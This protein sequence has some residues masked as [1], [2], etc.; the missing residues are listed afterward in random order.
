MNISQCVA[1]RLLLYMLTCSTC[2][3]LITPSSHSCTPLSVTIYAP[4]HSLSISETQASEFFPMSF[5]FIY[6]FSV[7]L[8]SSSPFL[9]DSTNI[10]LWG[11]W[12]P[13]IPTLDLHNIATHHRKLFLIK[14]VWLGTCPPLRSTTINL[15]TFPWCG[16]NFA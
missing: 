11:L 14:K 10:V 9:H 1:Y 4:S 2:S 6:S 8:S 3:V 16:K 12:M 7:L 5:L 15:S 13:D